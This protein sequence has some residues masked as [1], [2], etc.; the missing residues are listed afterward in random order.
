[1]DQ[2][3]CLCISIQKK[4]CKPKRHAGIENLAI[5]HKTRWISQINCKFRWPALSGIG[6]ASIPQKSILVSLLLVKKIIFIN[7][8]FC[9]LIK[10]SYLYQSIL[11]CYT[12]P[13]VKS[14]FFKCEVLLTERQYIVSLTSVWI[15]LDLFQNEFEN[16]SVNRMP[17]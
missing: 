6:K 14:Y 8:F 1:M 15:L 12:L 16:E 3:M 10:K 7:L 11:L 17:W 9:V 5:C 13:S 2:F 4:L